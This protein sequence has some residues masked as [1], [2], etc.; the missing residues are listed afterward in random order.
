MPGGVL[1]LKI[2]DIKKNNDIKNNKLELKK[3]I[4]AQ[5]NKQ[6][7]QFSTMYFNKIKKSIRINEI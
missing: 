3:L 5:K 7:N 2:D 1:I 6:L 4:N